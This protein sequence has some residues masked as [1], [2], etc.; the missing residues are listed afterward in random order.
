MADLFSILSTGAASL[1]AQRA[2]AATA[3]NNLENANTPGYARQVA[4]LT[5]TDPSQ[6]V[7]GVSLGT[8]ASV[9]TVQQLRDRFVEAQLPAAYGQASSSSVTADALE[10]VHALDPAATGG[11][12][13]AISGFYDAFRQLSQN[14]GDPS[15]RQQALAAASSLARSFQA[16]RGGVE[17]ARAGLDA[18]LSADVDE[19]NT[20]AATVARLNDEIRA[21]QASGAQPNDLLDARQKAVDRLEQLTGATPVAT[22]NGD[23]QLALA[24]GAALVTGD[25]AATLS[26]V[27]DPANGGHLALRLAPPGGAPAALPAVGGELGGI[28]S[29]RDGALETAV[30]QIDQL[31]W[32]LGSA[33]N[34]VHAAGYGLD[35]VSGRP[36]FDL[37]SGP[38]GAAASIAVSSA[39]ASNPSA[40]AAASSA[41]TVP[42]DGAGALALVGTET[43]AL[44]GGLDAAS[45]LSRITAQ[46]GSAAQSARTI[47]DHDGAMKDQLDQLRQSASGVSIDDELIQMQQAQQAYQAVLKVIQ[48]SNDMFD[49][50]MQIKPT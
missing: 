40:L 17:S 18:Q 45:T 6:T 15:M 31:A 1:A 25:Q 20:Q 28:L 26:A 29:A 22:A 44:S 7:G 9:Q 13:D 16:T 12:G 5:E 21:A 48:T 30:G 50:L 19:V 38:A 34:A 11:L 23:V 36:L 42:G 32:D 37:G 43:A 2:A 39:V 27:A 47:A 14:A 41:A 24:G 4:V 46:F 49:T 35:G 8:G 33:V 10:S 3:S